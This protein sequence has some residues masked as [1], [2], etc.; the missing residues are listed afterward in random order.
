MSSP[1]RYYSHRCSHHPEGTRALTQLNV[2]GVLAKKPSPDKMFSVK[3]LMHGL[4]EG[5]A[6]PRLP[7][8]D[9]C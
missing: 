7:R 6:L 3:G 8:R 1:V 9:E 4:F 2:R 5:Q